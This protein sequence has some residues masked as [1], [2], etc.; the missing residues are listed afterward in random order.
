MGFNSEEFDGAELER[1][2]PLYVYVAFDKTGSTT[3][4]G[5]LRQLGSAFVAPR[6]PDKTKGWVAY[7]Y[8]M[9]ANFDAKFVERRPRR[10]FTLIRKP[11][12]RL[13][14]AYN[15]FCLACAEQHRQCR[16]KEA[17]EI[18]PDLALHDY[19]RAFGI[20]TPRPSSI[21]SNVSTLIITLPQ[22]YDTA[23]TWVNE[24]RPFVMFTETLSEDIPRLFSQYFHY[25]LN[26]QHHHPRNSHFHMMVIP[27]QTRID[28]A[29]TYFAW[30]HMLYDF[31]WTHRR[32]SDNDP[33]AS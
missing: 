1:A 23:L 18:C 3:V 16:S 24:N 30:D 7:S 9:Y 29:K 11:I 12:D 22:D 31:L 25:P 14:S 20:Y 21:P 28:L 13:E 26:E 4:T 19:A 15:Y 32:S 5:V 10:Y 33:D 8:A 2:K 6:A 27:T 17:P